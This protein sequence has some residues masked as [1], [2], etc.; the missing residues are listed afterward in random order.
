MMHFVVL[1]TSERNLF[2]VIRALR[3]PTGFP[4]R[5]NRWQDEGHK[6]ADNGDHRNKFDDGEG[7][8]RHGHSFHD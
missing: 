7:S 4:R 6:N 3:S 5:L 1:Q 8:T 2:D